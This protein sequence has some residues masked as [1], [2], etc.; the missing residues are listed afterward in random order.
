[1][2]NKLYPPEL[3]EGPQTGPRQTPG[4][5]GWAD[6]LSNYRQPA[7]GL[8]AATGKK[9]GFESWPILLMAAGARAAGRRGLRWMSCRRARQSFACKTDALADL[10]GQ[11]EFQ[12]G[13][14]R[15]Q[16]LLRGPD[17]LHYCFRARCLPPG[18]CD[19]ARRKNSRA[20][21]PIFRPARRVPHQHRF[22]ALNF[23]KVHAGGQQRTES[24][25]FL[26]P[27]LPKTRLFLVLDKP[28]AGR[29]HQFSRQFSYFV[30]RWSWDFSGERADFDRSRF[31]I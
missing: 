15:D 2:I 18:L 25:Q 20:G 8:L 23:L 29:A 28:F 11:S 7:D 3:D 22:L 10:V 12:S 14:G 19:L 1:L 24:E 30:L 9:R 16:K 31:V 6:N 4:G 17:I 13:L 27:A 26:S 5:K 21:L